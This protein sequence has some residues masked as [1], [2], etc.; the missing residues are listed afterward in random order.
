MPPSMIGQL[1]AK[2]AAPRFVREKR[3]L[4]S[5]MVIAIVA[6]MASWGAVRNGERWLLEKESLDTAVKWATFA[7]NNLSDLVRARGDTH[8]RYERRNLVLYGR[9]YG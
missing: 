1:L 9:Y 4:I 5:L 8:R 7:R 6:L 3:L 2:N